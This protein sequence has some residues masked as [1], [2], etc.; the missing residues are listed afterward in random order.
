MKKKEKKSKK[1]NKDSEEGK[2]TQQIERISKLDVMLKIDKLKSIQQ[3]SISEGNKEKAIKLANEIIELAIR[4]N[5]MYRIKEQEDLL[6][7]IAKKEQ[8]KFFT[9]EVEKECLILNEKY[10]IL[11][12]ANKIPQ[13]H[14]QIEEFKEKYSN[15]PD[16]NTLALVKALLEKDQR[17][18]IRHLSTSH[19]E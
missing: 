14:E 6:Q 7:S 1:K 11:V 12:E 16:F 9:T 5:M 4:Y 3:V 2:D 10:D 13:A 18:W 17:T 15:N 8:Q 19:N